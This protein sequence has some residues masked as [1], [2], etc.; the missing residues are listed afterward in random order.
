CALPIYRAVA[1]SGGVVSDENPFVGVALG[2]GI[3]SGGDLTVEQSIFTGNKAIGGSGGNG[4]NGASLYVT[5][6]GL[7]GGISQSELSAT[8]VVSG[9]TFADNQ[10]IGGAPPTP[11]PTGPA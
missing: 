2:G 6:A 5:D 3:S 8:V 4:G 10:A 11:G 9:S 7:G 1:G